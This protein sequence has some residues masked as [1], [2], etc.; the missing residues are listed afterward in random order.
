MSTVIGW[1]VA[2]VAVGTASMVTMVIEGMGIPDAVVAYTLAL[3]N[4]S[5]Y[6]E[7]K[8]AARP[9]KAEP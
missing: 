2:S 4:Y 6:L 1:R 3:L 5:F 9:S 7:S 8:K